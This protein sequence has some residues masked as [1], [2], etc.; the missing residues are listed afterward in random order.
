MCIKSEKITIKMKT[1]AIL[2]DK[3]SLLLFVN[4]TQSVC[5]GGVLI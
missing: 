4:H 1:D 5:V 3:Y 2:V